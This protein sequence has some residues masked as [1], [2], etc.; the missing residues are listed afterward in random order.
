MADIIFIGELY[1]EKMLTDKIMHECVFRRL[2]GDVKNPIESDLEA[3]CKLL[4]TIGKVLD[5]PKAKTYMDAYF[6]RMLIS[7]RI[8][9]LLLVTCFLTEPIV[10]TVDTNRSKQRMSSI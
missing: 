4:T 9:Y 1:K 8:R 2:L 6:K 7:S 10:P 5:V 3:L